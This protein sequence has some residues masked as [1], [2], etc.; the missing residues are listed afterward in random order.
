ML[1]TDGR[2]PHI[3]GDSDQNESAQREIS[4][5]R[6]ESFLFDGVI[7]QLNDVVYRGAGAP[8]T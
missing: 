2:A 1:C 8:H 3:G 7:V 6:Y 5:R 4:E